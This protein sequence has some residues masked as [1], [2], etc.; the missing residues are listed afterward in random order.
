MYGDAEEDDW[1]SEDSNEEF[2]RLLHILVLLFCEE[3]GLGEV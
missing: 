3:N 1:L 2:H